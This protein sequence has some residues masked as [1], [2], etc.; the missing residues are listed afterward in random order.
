MVASN[1]T[2]FQCDT[3]SSV[4]IVHLVEIDSNLNILKHS[5][6]DKSK[7]YIH[8]IQEDSP[9]R[10]FI[11]GHYIDSVVCVQIAGAKSSPYIG[12]IDSNNQV[13]WEIKYK[14][15]GLISFD[16]DIK[17]VKKLRDGN[18]LATGVCPGPKVYDASWNSDV[19]PK[20]GLIIKFNTQGEI[21]WSKRYYYLYNQYY[22]NDFTIN[23]I[24]E[25]SNKKL[26]AIGYAR[27][28][29]IPLK[30]TSGQRG[31]VLVM[32][33][34]GNLLKEDTVLSLTN[35]IKSVD[36]IS[37]YP[38]PVKKILNIDFDSEPDFSNTISLFNSIGQLCIVKTIQKM[39]NHIDLSQLPN[40]T[41]IVKIS[42][43]QMVL[44]IQTIL[45]P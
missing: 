8:D 7:V 23:D 38:N 9:N 10:F 6:F 43:H 40:G 37:I 42:N 29:G 30:D 39:K 21:L 11:Y 4:Y 34:L 45:K 33:S 35:T 16:S 14:V 3:N 31:W 2:R 26:V 5:I 25:L 15:K 17:K 24:T 28:N 22:D 20:H 13:I 36:I 44:A 27:L 12:L 19:Y 41:Y 18:Y 32:D 1:E